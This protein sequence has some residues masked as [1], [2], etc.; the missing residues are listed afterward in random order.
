MS[1]VNMILVLSVSKQ[2]VSKN[3]SYLSEE[4]KKGRC[5][6]HLPK[7]FIAKNIKTSL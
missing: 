1:R 6:I 2:Y 5:T 7:I 3:M 4:T